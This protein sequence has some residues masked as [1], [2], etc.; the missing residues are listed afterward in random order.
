MGI[1]PLALAQALVL[2]TVSANAPPLRSANSTIRDNDGGGL[3]VYTANVT[4][5]NSTVT[6]NTSE[7]HGG[8]NL[9]VAF[10]TL[11]VQNSTIAN[12]RAPYGGGLAGEH[13]SMR[14]SILA[15][16]IATA[17]DPDCYATI[18]TSD[19]NIIGNTFGCTVTAGTGDNFYVGPKYFSDSNR[20]HWLLCAAVRKPGY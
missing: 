2:V 14:N 11:M 9:S 17:G 4:L 19:H 20:G 18:N 15:N 1:L 6:G 3:Y 7:G 5:S 16:N 8:C 12:N 10:G 13:I